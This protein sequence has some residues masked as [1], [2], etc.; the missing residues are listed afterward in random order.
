[1]HFFPGAGE[2]PSGHI[3]KGIHGGLGLRMSMPSGLQGTEEK[4]EKNYNL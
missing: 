1:M 2:G 3:A 4:I